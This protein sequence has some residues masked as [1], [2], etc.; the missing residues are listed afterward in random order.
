MEE[1]NNTENILS[2]SSSTCSN[3]ISC[4]QKDNNEVNL[5]LCEKNIIQIGERPQLK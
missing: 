4:L 5:D 2:N 1:S 3:S